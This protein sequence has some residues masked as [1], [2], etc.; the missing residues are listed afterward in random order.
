MGFVRSITRAVRGVVRGVTDVAKGAINF[1]T[2]AI[3]TVTQGALGLAGAVL[4]RLPFGN[5]IKGFLGQFMQNP[6]GLLALGTL[7]GF[8]ALLA[9]ASSF[10]QLRQASDYCCQ[11][12]AY[13]HPCARQNVAYMMAYNQA[14]ILASQYTGGYC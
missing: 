10:G 11:C 5:A 6:F 9:G 13:E 4:D 7:G 1:A 8:G 14:R 12:P 2:K 3:S